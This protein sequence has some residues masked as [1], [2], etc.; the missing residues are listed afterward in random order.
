MVGIYLLE[1]GKGGG[2]RI[3]GVWVDEAERQ[4]VDAKRS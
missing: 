3:D 1:W 2:G 4:R